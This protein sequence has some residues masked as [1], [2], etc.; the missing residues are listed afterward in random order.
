MRK[1]AKKKGKK[2]GSL[3]FCNVH[4]KKKTKK[5][6]KIVPKNSSEPTVIFCNVRKQRWVTTFFMCTSSFFLMRTLK[7]MLLKS[8]ILR[9]LV[10]CLLLFSCKNT[11]KTQTKCT[12]TVRVY[13]KEGAETLLF[14]QC[15]HKKKVR[16]SAKTK[17]KNASK[18]WD[19]YFFCIFF[20]M[21]T[22]KKSGI[23]TFFMYSIAFFWCTLQKNAKKVRFLRTFA[24]YSLLFFMY[25]KK[26]ENPQK[27]TQK[28]VRTCVHKK[29]R[30]N[31]TFFAM[32]AQKKSPKIRK[33]KQKYIKN[34]GSLL[35]LL[36]FFHVH[37]KK[38]WDH[39]F[40][41]VQLCFFGVHYKKKCQKVQKKK[42]RQKK[43][44]NP[45]KKRFFFKK[46]T[47]KKLQKLRKKC[48]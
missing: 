31:T 36:C 44:K 24:I 28:N 47:Q 21:C 12:Q 37:T 2:L 1:S 33:K 18:T 8:A 34:L 25:T 45:Q 42:K 29:K 22:L 38:K 27:K 23:T 48:P 39:Y 15:T 40:F 17:S 4:T 14:L 32:Y 9:T 11:K 16:K 10:T 43:Y 6:A 13:I 46:C 20:F 19:H 41:Y 30:G 5:N 3:L 26:Y 35:F 7:K